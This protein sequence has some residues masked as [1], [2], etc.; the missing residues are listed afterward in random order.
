MSLSHRERKGKRVK[1][2]KRRV[3][4]KRKRKG[5]REEGKKERWIE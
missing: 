1:G 5:K 3:K 4:E 2:S